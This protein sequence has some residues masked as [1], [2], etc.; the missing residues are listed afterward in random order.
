[1]QWIFK[2]KPYLF[3]NEDNLLNEGYCVFGRWLGHKWRL[4]KVIRVNPI[5]A[6]GIMA[7]AKAMEGNTTV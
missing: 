2:L 4:I 3:L 1:M 6:F 7:K 5:N